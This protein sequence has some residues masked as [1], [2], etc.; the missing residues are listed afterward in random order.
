MKLLSIIIPVYNSEPWLEKCIV[1]VENQNVA[2]S[3]FEVIIVNDGSK[4]NSLHIAQE[5]RAKY[6]NI[7]II[8]KANG[9]LSS[10]RNAGIEIATGKYLMFIDSDDY[11][12]PNSLAHLIQTCQENQLD[13]C[14]FCM[15]LVYP[16]GRITTG[17]ISE[18]DENKIYNGIQLIE[19]GLII[20]SAC[21][22][23]Y[24]AN[25]FKKYSLRFYE[26]ITHEDVEFKLRILCHV[27]RAMMLND[28]V[29]NYVMREDSMSH[30]TSYESLQKNLCDSVLV[31]ALGNKYVTEA[32]LDKELAETVYRSTNTGM[33]GI[34]LNL[35]LKHQYPISIVRRFLEMARAYS[36]YPI[37]RKYISLRQKVVSPLLNNS[38]LFIAL[39]SYRRREL[40]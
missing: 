8:D 27:N 35:L 4:D 26:G 21:S 24:L 2:H 6:S 9:G 11:I 31:A 12:K 3:D 14:H 30:N 23:V 1:S 20:G 18:Y 15:N 25:I 33:A 40:D 38:R 16:D 39:Y 36:V 13:L 29:Y 7:T 17:T 28:A 34:L 37:N 5:L 10:A 22:S 32:A 19:S